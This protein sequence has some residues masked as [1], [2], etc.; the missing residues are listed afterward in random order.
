MIYNTDIV[1]QEVIETY[2]KTLRKIIKESSKCI[3]SF[4]RELLEDEINRSES[5]KDWIG[6]M[7][8]GKEINLTILDYRVTAM[9]EIIRDLSEKVDRLENFGKKTE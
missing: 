1:S 8:L 3:D 2:A 4:S 9:E 7:L 6:L 5:Q